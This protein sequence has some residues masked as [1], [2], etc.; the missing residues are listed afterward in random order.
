MTNI[1]QSLLAALFAL[2]GIS[3]AHAQYFNDQNQMTNNRAMNRDGYAYNTSNNQ[4]DVR[5][6]TAPDRSY[7]Y[8]RD[9]KPVNRYSSNTNRYNQFNR[10]YGFNQPYETD[11]AVVPTDEINPSQFSRYD[12]SVG[13]MQQDRQ[14]LQGQAQPLPTS[15]YQSV[16]TP[17]MYNQTMQ[18]TYVSTQ[19]GMPMRNTQIPARY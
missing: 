11:Y 15:Q 4:N 13:Q 10:P 6:A 17:D 7:G 14:M 12:N 3:G 2:A 9:N 16:R 5:Q 19:S 18:Q 1:K 8:D